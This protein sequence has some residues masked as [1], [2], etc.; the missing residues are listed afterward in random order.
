MGPEIRLVQE[1]VG[2]RLL[3]RVFGLRYM[4]INI[5]YVLSFRSAGAVLAAL[6]VRAVF[7]TGGV[8]L[9]ALA[10][11]GLLCF[12]PDR[13]GTRLPAVPEPAGAT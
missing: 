13:I 7:V 12:R 2:E 11:A 3:G 8:C 10:I 9:V 5:A 1:L 6:G 4:L